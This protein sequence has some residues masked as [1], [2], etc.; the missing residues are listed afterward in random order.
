V[1]ISSSRSSSVVTWRERDLVS[2]HEKAGRVDSSSRVVLVVV[3]VGVWVVLGS[4]G[5]GPW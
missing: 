5:R 4:C 1:R 3:W 2:V